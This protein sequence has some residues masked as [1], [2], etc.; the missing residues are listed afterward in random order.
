VP[1]DNLKPLE[2]IW[3][4]GFLP[5]PTPHSSASPSASPTRNQVHRR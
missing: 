1:T 3:P 2:P 5:S 4:N